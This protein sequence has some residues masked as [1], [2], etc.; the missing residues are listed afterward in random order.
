MH[1]SCGMSRWIVVLFGFC[2]LQILAQPII[3]NVTPLL[4][5]PGDLVHITGMGFYPGVLKVTFNG[6]VDPT[7][8]ATTY[9]QIQAMVPTGATSGRIT[10]QVDSG[11]IA[12]SPQDF[13]VVGSG[14]YI[15][16]FSPVFG[17]PGNLILI[18]GIHFSPVT[19]AYFNGKSAALFVQSDTQIQAQVPVGAT[20]GPISVGSPFGTNTT[21]TN[22]F[23]PP[24]ITSFTPTSGRASTNV[25]ILGTNLLGTTAVAFNN[26]LASTINILSNGAVQVTVPGL[27][28]T[29]KI[30]IDT[31]AGPAYTTG[32]FTVLPT[33]YGFT[34]IAGPVGTSV[35]ITGANLYGA[36]AVKFNGAS[37]APSGVTF[38][39]VTAVVPASATTGPIS[40]TTT[41][42]SFTNSANFYLPASITTF[43]P[44]NSPP[45]T[46]VK[47]TGNN[48]IG[49]TNITFGGVPAADFQVTNN[50]TIG[51]VVPAGVVT[52]P[53]AIFTPAGVFTNNMRFYGLPLITSFQPTI[54]L[55][56]TNVT[57]YGTNFLGATAVRF[58]GLNAASFTAT[59]NGLLRAVVPNGVTA[60]PISVVAPAGTNQ[61]SAPFVV[62]VSDL[63]VSVT[64]DP[65]AEV[66][67]GSNL[68]YTVTVNNLGPADAPNVKATNTCA[69][70]P[71]VIRSA[72]VS[73]GNLTTNGNV[74]SASLGPV[75]AG[76]SAT[77]VIKVTTPLAGTITNTVRVTSDFLDLVTTNNTASVSTAVLPLP[78][79]SIRLLTNTVTVSWPA[80]LANYDL[81]Y[82]NALLATNSWSNVTVAPKT[83][84]QTG[85]KFV[86]ET[87]ANPAKFYRLSQP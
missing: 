54:G 70:P 7:A 37:V 36:S 74:V 21:A 61:S 35:T 60:G 41:N 62:A 22:F 20:T 82:V 33:I 12:Y 17:S 86:S 13:T 59:N 4:G 67:V 65:A 24:A 31:P 81:Q 57:I 83:N 79:L 84:T 1:F 9:N 51:A 14:P 43:T 69:A 15:T 45:G 39:Q 64:T 28:T 66:F 23:I 46:T 78:L 26:V 27:A 38:S 53:I 44:T 63:T 76:M 34:P 18:T 11:Q 49:T 3:T 56:G 32:N 19:G 73:Q 2:Q 85:E 71:L 68:T 8:E 6:V 72:T 25:L 30:R 10:V 87:N 16:G 80:A 47:I 50:T 77:L 5:S 42:G 52:G 58:N 29:G 48:F 55:S 40:I 75:A